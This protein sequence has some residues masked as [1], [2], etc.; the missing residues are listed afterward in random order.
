MICVDDRI[1]NLIAFFLIGLGFLM[2][3][4][5]IW[6]FDIMF[7]RIVW[8][9]FE[10]ATGSLSYLHGIEVQ[11]FTR[12]A[13]NPFTLNE[14][15]GLIS[16]TGTMYDVLMMMDLAGWFMTVAGMYLFHFVSLEKYKRLYQ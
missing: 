11:G 7:M 8:T 15:L 10:G 6:Q 12:L 3:A 4:F 1:K 13:D 14:E 16:S 5:S 9:P 2:I